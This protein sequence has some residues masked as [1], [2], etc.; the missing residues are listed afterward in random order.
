MAPSPPKAH[1]PRQGVSPCP[2][3]SPLP[4]NV[5]M[6]PEALET[7]P[8]NPHHRIPRS[9]F[10]YHLASCLRKNLR[11]AKAMATCKYNACHVLPIKK[12]QEHEAACGDR[13]NLEEEDGMSTSSLG[14]G[15]QGPS[16]DTWNMDNSNCYPMFVLKPFVPQK[17]VCESTPLMAPQKNLRPGQ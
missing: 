13:S 3:A 16:A 12:L 14:N 8:Y 7:C 11:K 1:P 10:Q 15:L 17:L 9:R 2:A 4:Q 6:E 5:L